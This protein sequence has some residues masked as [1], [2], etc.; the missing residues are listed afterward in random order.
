MTYSVFYGGSILVSLRSILTL[1]RLLAE[2][3]P[4]VLMEATVAFE[5]L[6]AAR[7]WIDFWFL[8]A[9]S[10]LVFL[11]PPAVFGNDYEGSLQ[12]SFLASSDN[13]CLPEYGS[14]RFGSSVPMKVLAFVNIS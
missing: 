12:M 8:R 3:S 1:P 6:F 4:A 9:K 5:V 14:W 10:P 13:I 11:G 7:P 2:R